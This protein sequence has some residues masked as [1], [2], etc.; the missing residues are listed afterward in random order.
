[1]VFTL[2]Q[3]FLNY[4]KLFKV[5]F[6]KV[7]KAGSRT[8]RKKQL[9]RIRIEKNSWIRIRK[10]WIQIP[11][12]HISRVMFYFTFGLLGGG[13]FFGLFNIR[14]VTEKGGKRVKAG[15]P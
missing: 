4:R 5:I 9:I 15:L 12:R 2:V 14:S 7:L 1:M 13:V 10:K 6:S 8:A 3:S 11:G